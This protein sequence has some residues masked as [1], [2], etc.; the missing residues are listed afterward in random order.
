[1]YTSLSLSLSLSLSIDTRMYS[2]LPS[3]VHHHHGQQAAI[4]APLSHPA[5]LF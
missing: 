2:F 5:R 1:M 4:P 3:L